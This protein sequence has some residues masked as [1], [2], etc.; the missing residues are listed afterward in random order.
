M[1]KERKKFLNTTK[2]VFKNKGE[3]KPY[4]DKQISRDFVPRRLILQEIL[5]EVLQVEQK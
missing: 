3:I 4:P 5:K 2:L 1:L